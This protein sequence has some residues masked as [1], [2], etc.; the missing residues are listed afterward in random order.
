MNIL[1]YGANN[2]INDQFINTTLYN[3][4]RTYK[5]IKYFENSQYLTFPII[6]IHILHFIKSLIQ[7]TTI[8]NIIRKII[9]LNIEQLDHE[10][11]IILRIILEK[12]NNTTA[13]IATTTQRS[14]I[15]KPILSRFIAIRIPVHKIDIEITP[16][17][18][19]IT[20]PTLADIKKIVKK[21]RKY[22]IKD[23]SL[24]LLKIT[25]YKL[26][27]IEHATNIEH[28]HC[29]HNNKELAIETLFLVCFY[30]P[31]YDIKKNK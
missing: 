13:F 8:N 7:T 11:M 5:N 25:P 19:I 20:K 6:N 2:T 12:Y 31:K 3:Q 15:D 23:I 21:C 22:S 18:K 10:S 27:F 16:I 28:Q 30:P 26:Q 9:L 29:F 14:K 17:K 24:E 1:Y 4:T